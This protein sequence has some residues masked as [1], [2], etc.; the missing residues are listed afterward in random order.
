MIIVITIIILTIKISRSRF[1]W[2]Q[3]RRSRRRKQQRSF[4]TQWPCPPLRKH[5]PSP[6]SY[7]ERRPTRWRS[8]CWPKLSSTLCVTMCHSWSTRHQIHFPF[9]T[10]LSTMCHNTLQQNGTFRAHVDIHDNTRELWTVS[11]KR[12]PTI[13]ATICNYKHLINTSTNQTN[14]QANDK[15]RRGSKK[16][17]TIYVGSNGLW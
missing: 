7:P 3:S 9:F 6:P 10:Q 14:Q 11:W 5:I 12:Y 8:R 4:R 1:L 17:V 2:S 15:C 13:N 16:N